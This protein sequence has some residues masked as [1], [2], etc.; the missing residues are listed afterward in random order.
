MK[1]SKL[2]RLIWM[3]GI[4][5][6]LGLI[7]YLV[8]TYKVEWEGKDLNTYL[9]LYDCSHELC[10]STTI[11]KDYYDKILCEE[12][13][14]P[15]ISDIIGNNLIFKRDN[16]SWIYN[17]I[18]GNIISDDYFDYRYIGYNVYAVSDNS[19]NYGII[20]GNGNEIVKLEY[21]YIDSYNNGFI[22]YIND[23]LYG[24]VSTDGKY[25]I[26]PVYND[27]VLINDKIFAGMKDN[28][29]HLYSYD[30]VDNENANAYNF[31]YSY[32]GIVFVINNKKVDILDTNLNS[33][34][35]MK[36]NTFY[37]Y[38]TEKERDSL[39]IYTDEEYIYFKIFTNET[40][41]I[42][43]KYSIKDKKLI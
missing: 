24:I 10:T 26:K 16:M 2:W 8:V 19:G 33:T 25:K 39:E 35:I 15:Y 32:D 14:C 21:K 6:I 20:D 1:S 27:V 34:L 22:S 23:N 40:E 31:V 29:Y 3:I 13:R 12:G 17:Y 42:N 18:D 28:I 5:V 4:Y 38:K 9:Y 7:L 43:Y 41:Y 30:N 36:I 11:Q 37:E